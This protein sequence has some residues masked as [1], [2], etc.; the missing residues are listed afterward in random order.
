[1]KHYNLILIV[2]PYGY[3]II[4]Y[5]PFIHIIYTISDDSWNLVIL[6]L[7]LYNIQIW[8]SNYVTLYETLYGKKMNKMKIK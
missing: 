7:H 1:M 5:I 6:N 2:L 3:Q 4:I 8:I